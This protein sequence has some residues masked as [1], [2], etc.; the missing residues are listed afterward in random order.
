MFGC[1]H[2]TV[3]VATPTPQILL[4][5]ANVSFA[6]GGLHAVVGPSGCG[7]TTLVKA[8]LGLIAHKGDV[9]FNGAQVAGAD[10][11]VG[12]VG[13][14]PQFSIAP[15]RLSVRECLCSTY[16]LAVADRAGES[17]RIAEILQ[18]VGL[19]A[20]ADKAVQSLSGGQLRRLGL[21]QEL[22][23][24]PP[25]LVCD[26]VTSGLDPVSEDAILRL[27][28]EICARTGKTVVCIIHNLEKLPLFDTVAFLYAG[29]VLF[30]GS[31]PELRAHVGVD[32]P[33][34]LY[35]ACAQKPLE[36]WIGRAR[37]PV[38]EIPLAQ[39]PQPKP[40]PG[41]RRQCAVLLERRARLFFR[42]TGTL[43]PMLVM[44][45]GFPLVVILF[46]WDG[47]PQL[48]QIGLTD[49]GAFLELMQEKIRYAQQAASVSLL[50]TGLILFQITLLGLMASNN[51][52]REI[53]GE[54]ALYEK[55][56]LIGVRPMAY[57]ASK[58]AYVT[59]LSVFQ[60]LLMLFLVKYVCLFPGSVWWQGALLVGS[61]VS[62]SF[63]CLG[64]SALASSPDKSSL[65]S[66]YLVGFQLP[67][68]GV[69]LALPHAL[70]W[71][72]RPFINA[73]WTWSGTFA[74]MKDTA[75]YDAFRFANDDWGWIPGPALAL[76]VLILQ[77]AA[78]ALCVWVGCFR[79]R[80]N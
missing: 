3:E 60:G 78:G 54:R 79:R 20:H 49:A 14:A 13:F 76:G 30:Q 35:E 75:F 8:M 31:L 39:A 66:I 9:F 7:K 47:L 25:V 33:S 64:F 41:V 18:L 17:A 73:Y 16:R 29:R 63:V 80:W 37:A 12:R 28:R 15:A 65:F 48:E 44:A 71:V 67:L 5:D 11:L 36:Y 27:L 72:F 56:R 59:G 51:G 4:D 45:V 34:E 77:A 40:R 32:K 2:L 70:E 19:D 62:M 23:A 55:E 22:M 43:L 10:A 21:A 52:S 38:P 46:A 6:A 68:S 1:A 26:E 61:T 53:A 58:F 57:I 42:D 50:V 69:I 24:D 74:T